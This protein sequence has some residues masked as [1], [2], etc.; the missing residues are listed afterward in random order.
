MK[1]LLPLILYALCCI[2]VYAAPDSA[3]TDKPIRTVSVSGCAIG[4]IQP[5]TVLWTLTPQANAKLLAEAREACEKQVKVLLDRCAKKGIQGPDVT[6]GRL[7]IRDALIKQGDGQQGPE[8]FTVSR[9]I[10]LRQRDL[11]LFHDMLNDLSTG[12][13]GK[14]NYKLFCSRTD[15]ITRETLLR[16]TQA[17]KDKAGAMATV[18]GAKLGAALSV[19]EFAP[20]NTAVSQE[21]LLIDDSSPVYS[22]DAQKINIAVYA[23]FEL[24]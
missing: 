16:A 19:S 17:A 24:Q 5:D 21:Q 4:Y 18:L 11:S 15:A 13:S 9:T 23:T 6:L 7:N 22:S 20:T 3:P 14:V 1:A 10:T 12:G 2:N 8:R